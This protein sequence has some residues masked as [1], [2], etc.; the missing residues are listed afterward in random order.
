MSSAS[1][2][3][4]S[5]NGAEHSSL[6]VANK[7]SCTSPQ[8]PQ[9]PKNRA[10]IFRKVD[11][12]YSSA[13]VNS[14]APAGTDAT[15][16]SPADTYKETHVSSVK[17]V[18]SCIGTTVSLCPP[19]PES[20]A[21]GLAKNYPGAESA[22]LDR[23]S[24]ARLTNVGPYKDH[25][26]Y[27]SPSIS[28]VD[29][30]PPYGV[31]CPHNIDHNFNVSICEVCGLDLCNPE[32]IDMHLRLHGPEHD[33]QGDNTS[34]DVQGITDPSPSPITDLT[35]PFKCDI[36]HASFKTERGLKIHTSKTGHFIPPDETI[37]DI[38]GIPSGTPSKE[39]LGLIART[40][41]QLMRSLPPLQA[42]AKLLSICR[43]CESSGRLPPCQVLVRK[44]LLGRAWQSI[45]AST[46]PVANIPEPVGDERRRI[47]QELH[48]LPQL[49]ALPQVSHKLGPAPKV[50]AVSL[51]KELQ[52][53][54]NVA[55]GPSGLGKIHLLH[56]CE[57]ASAGEH[58]ASALSTLYARRD[59]STLKSL[60]EFRLRLLAK[61]NG[62]WRPIAIQETLLV[63]FHKLIL[64]QTQPL[65]RMPSWQLAFDQLAQM[66]AIKLAEEYKKTCH[67][68]TIDVKNAFNSVPHQ[69]ISF[70]LHRAG[71]PQSTVSYIE[72]FL[73]ARHTSDLGAVPAG[74][75]QGDPLSMAI[76]CQSIVWPIE[77]FLSN[78]RVIAYADDIVL[79]S[80]PH[81]NTDTVKEEARQALAKVGLTV[82]PSKCSSTSGGSIS[83][84]GTKV[85]KD[86]PYNLAEMAT[87]GL[88]SYLEALHNTD[89]SKH[90]KLRLLVFCITPSVNYGP[91]I[92]QY[93]G[94]QS[95][96]E[97]DALLIGEIAELLGIHTSVASSIALTPRSGYG[98]GL[99]LP[100]YYHR[101]MQEQ[102]QQMS[103][104]VF[105]DLRKRMLRNT[106][107]LKSFLPLALL[108]GPP[109]N[110]D[111]MLYVGECASGLFG[112]NIVMGTC[113]YCKQPMRP[114][115]H[116]HCK[117]VN[118]FHVARHEK[119]IDALIASSRKR[120]GYITKNAAIPIDHLQPDLI[121]G[122]GFADLVVT[123]PWRIEKSYALKMAKYRPLIQRGRAAFF[124]PIVISTDGTI[125]PISAIELSRAGVDLMRFKLETAHI[126]L[127][128]YTRSA[129]EYTSLGSTKSLPS[130]PHEPRTNEQI[131]EKP[132]P[133]QADPSTCHTNPTV[134][135]RTPALPSSNPSPSVEILT[136][137]STDSW[138]RAKAELLRLGASST[139]RRNDTQ[140][141]KQDP[142][143]NNVALEAPQDF[144]VSR[145]P[146]PVLTYTSQEPIYPS[147][148]TLEEPRCKQLSP[149]SKHLMEPISSIAH[150]LP[151]IFKRSE[152]PPP[153]VRGIQKN[154]CK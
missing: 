74:V 148:R 54:K 117:S 152:T 85:L 96:R 12:G 41:N 109:L 81:I 61:P 114:R 16:H 88:Y 67:L 39:L 138:K 66:K 95:Y 127:W 38:I 34:H 136:A 103:A 79:A 151:C 69:V 106:T 75:P 76:F 72:S 125:H 20:H 137:P 145:A 91:L 7:P 82:E 14:S 6:P 48:P 58:F 105:R 49:V 9:L 153:M 43:R 37:H 51:I 31:G 45:L 102:R 112:K 13:Q 29:L 130:K 89:L 129:I 147:D 135:V 62:K 113:S 122:N 101:E 24:S 142:A 140:V 146:S 1:H 60:A 68:T 10:P 139:P 132:N 23:T 141:D 94:P 111:Q 28:D 97:V 11:R 92:D 52:S 144:Q 32:D 118:G 100:H 22:K 120:V 150:H 128:H 107:P 63:V 149:P 55:S 3:P 4:S 35:C 18:T 53:M 84:M 86:G 123:V 56:L 78:Y 70:S 93:P 30:F 108:R 124:L 19:I 5:N 154:G 80:D 26:Y 133:S 2:M 83:F 115:H 57:H 121:I 77:T 27:V 116:L 15:L 36:C 40:Y 99:V 47:I 17:Q 59:W 90:E 110:D 25:D 8:E 50:S 143:T 64:K 87:R 104:G 134:Q 42:L 46:S 71:V 131:P 126:I 44:G 65:R 119:I 98:L 33:V 73:M 21:L